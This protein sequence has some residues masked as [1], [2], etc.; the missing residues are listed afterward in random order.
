M[1]HYDVVSANRLGNRKNNQDRFAVV[2]SEHAV[3]MIMADGMGGHSGG[4][5]ASQTLV[6]TCTQL[7]HNTPTPIVDPALFLNQVIHIA[8]QDVVRA[9]LEHQPPLDPRTTCVLCLVQDGYAWWAHV[10]DSR[11]YHFR[12][13]RG[14]HRTI[15]HSEVEDLYRQGVITAGQKHN[16]PFQNLVTQCIGSPTREPRP[17]LAEKVALQRGDILLL[18]TDGFWSPFSEAYI[19]RQLREGELSES[20]EK[21]ATEA[22][23]RT[24]PKSDNISVMVLRWNDSAAVDA[25]P[26]ETGV[27]YDELAEGLDQITRAVQDLEGKG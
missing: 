4:E 17:D 5:L 16:H 20:V 25:S 19:G 1:M 24:F 26:L 13:S 27:E 2:E 10:G 15:D 9:G 21:L 12:F 8:Q 22:E 6:D 11:L 14:I 18:C 3:L 23:T 7:F